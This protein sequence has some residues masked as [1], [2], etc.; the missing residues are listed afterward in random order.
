VARQIGKPCV[1]GCAALVIDYGTRS[2]RVDGLGFSE[3]EWISLDGTTGEVFIG[4]LPTTAARFEDQAE[5]QKVLEWADRARR[6]EV[7]TNA[8]K[9]EEAA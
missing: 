5:L 7:W 6:L 2:A 4:A 1:A 3:G 9:P 8:D